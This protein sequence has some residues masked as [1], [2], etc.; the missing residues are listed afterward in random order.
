MNDLHPWPRTIEQA[1]IVQDQLRDRVIL[2]DRLGEVR[3]VGGADL[4]FEEQGTIARAAVVVLSFPEL[5]RVEYAIARMP[6]PFPYVPGFLSFREVPAI[7]QAFEQ[8]HQKPDVILCDGQGYAHPRRFGLACH[9]GVLLDLPTIGAAKSRLIGEHDPLGPAKGD[10][11]PTL[12]RAETVGAVVRSRHNC[13]PLYVS[14]GHRVSLPTAIDLVLRCTTRY[15]LPETTRW[16][17]AIASQRG[18]YGT[19]KL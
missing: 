8:L 18:A 3:W 9:L 11:Q 17:D 15:R 12:D 14:S 19:V 4:G 10:W 5:E 6:T 2:D 7:L 1:R 13:R 16:A